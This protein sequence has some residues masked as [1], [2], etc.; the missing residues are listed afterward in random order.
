MWPGRGGTG[1]VPVWSW[2]NSCCSQAEG[3]AGEGKE[4]AL[5]KGVSGAS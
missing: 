1:S 3:G 2:W 5:S 4:V